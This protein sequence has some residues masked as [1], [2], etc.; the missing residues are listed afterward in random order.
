MAGNDNLKVPQLNRDVTG[1][2]QTIQDLALL[3]GMRFVV[4]NQKV[5]AFNATADQVEPVHS[6]KASRRTLY[7]EVH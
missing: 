1:L 5:K 2:A 7:P 3:V 4:D 6:V